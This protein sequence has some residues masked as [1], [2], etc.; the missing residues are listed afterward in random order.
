MSRFT[1]ASLMLV[2]FSISHVFAGHEF[3]P[4]ATFS[5]NSGTIYSS[6]YDLGF[7]PATASPIGEGKVSK[8]IFTSYNSQTGETI[9]TWIDKDTN[10]PYFSIFDETNWG[11]SQA[12]FTEAFQAYSEVYTTY[13]PST[14]VTVATFSNT[15][16]VPYYSVYNNG[17]WTEPQVLSQDP[18]ITAY[19]MIYTA[20]DPVSGNIVGVFNGNNTNPVLYTVYNGTTWTPPTQIAPDV[21][22]FIDVFIS[23]NPE[24]KQLVA[25]WASNNFTIF[26]Y[27]IFDGTNWTVNEI[28]NIYIGENIWT[29]YDYSL[30]K[31]IATYSSANIPMFSIFEN[32]MFGTQQNINNISSVE[33]NVNCSYDPNSKKTIAVWRNNSVGFPTVSVFDGLTWS[34]EEYFDDEV[35]TRSVFTTVYQEGGALNPPLNLS[36]IQFKNNFGLFFE[37]VTELSWVLSDSEGVSGYNVV[38]NGVNIGSVGALETKYQAHNQ[39]QGANVVY[40]VIPFDADGNEGTAATV[41]VN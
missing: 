20:F 2:M 40:E 28:E 33:S 5:I 3:K 23:Y 18:S 36:A 7:L 13:N 34:N 27:G 37:I 17:I 19:N 11:V 26:N 31:L 14:N 10:F 8:N 24:I 32:N 6:V 39:T 4:I 29:S 38:A 22:V 9:A 30:Q 1:S 21:F 25:T 16:Q 12:M 35:P 15:E 41:V